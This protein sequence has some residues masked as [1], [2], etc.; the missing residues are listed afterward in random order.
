MASLR[1]MRV[2][3]RARM[4]ASVLRVCNTR[5]MTVTDWRR[6]RSD[7]REKIHQWRRRNELK[8]NFVGGP[9]ISGRRT[10]RTNMCTSSRTEYF[11]TCFYPIINDRV[12]S[13]ACMDT[14]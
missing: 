2:R 10:I 9:A 12:C 1:M 14:W 13:V 6:S 8:E 11:L 7:K 5:T 4:C 3:V